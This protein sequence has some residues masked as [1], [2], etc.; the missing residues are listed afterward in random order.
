MIVTIVVIA[1][2]KKK[3]A[4]AAIIAIIWNHS[5]AIAATTISAIVVAA[6]AGEWFPY[7]HW[8]FF[9]SAIAA[10]TAIVAIIWKPGL[11]YR[12]HPPF[13]LNCYLYALQTYRT[14]S[15]KL[16]LLLVR[17]AKLDHRTDYPIW[18]FSWLVTSLP[19]SDSRRHVHLLN[20]KKSE[21]WSSV[22]SVQI[23][24]NFR[25][26]V[27]IFCTQIDVILKAY[28]WFVL[29]STWSVLPIKLENDKSTG[30][31]MV[32]ACSCWLCFRC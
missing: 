30:L 8:T 12:N 29:L 28:C 24:A 14:H 19:Q 32:K 5:L 15:S 13:L 10:I 6:I 4:I 21:K 27:H 9:F 22:G 26:R 7:D 18:C 1:E 23:H 31:W 17:L 2:K 16:R 3:S 25:A 11:I 20:Q